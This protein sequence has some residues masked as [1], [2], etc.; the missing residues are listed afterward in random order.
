MIA[1]YAYCAIAALSLLD[2]LPQHTKPGQKSSLTNV[3]ATIQWLVSRQTGY[4]EEDSEDESDCSDQNTSKAD[5]CVE[6][7][8]QTFDFVGFN[9]RCNKVV[10]TCYAFWVGGSIDVCSCCCVTVAWGHA[11]VISRFLIMMFKNW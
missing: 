10:D 1:G 5:V 4:Y 9:G 11:N 3:P 7:E 6:D 8:Y 2:R